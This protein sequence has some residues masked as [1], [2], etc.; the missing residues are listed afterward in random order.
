VWG[1]RLSTQDMLLPARERWATFSS[2]ERAVLDYAYRDAIQNPQKVGNYKLSF[3]T[4]MGRSLGVH[5]FRFG[6]ANFV[7]IDVIN[8]YKVYDLWLDEAIAL[9]AE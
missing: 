3:V 4:L 2:E 6:Y 8:C 9:A 5:S 1:N 7:L